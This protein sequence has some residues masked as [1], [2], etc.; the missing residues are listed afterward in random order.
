[1]IDRWLLAFFGGLDT[2]SEWIDK[3]FQPKLKIKK[4]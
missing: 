4:K 3:L 2:I 1:M